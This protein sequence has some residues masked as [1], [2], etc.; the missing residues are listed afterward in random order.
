MLLSAILLL[1]LAAGIG[2]LL[3]REDL[4]EP[5]QGRA[6]GPA[7][8]SSGGAPTGAEPA[9]TAP[10][11]WLLPAGVRDPELVGFA[12]WTNDY[13]TANPVERA[14]ILPAG[15]ELATARRAFLLA[16]IPR[17]PAS[18]LAAAV[19][20]EVRTELPAAIVA[21]LEVPV[22][23]AGEYLVAI[24]CGDRPDHDPASH[25]GE[26][27]PDGITRNLILA[28]ELWHAFPYGRRLDT[29]TKTVIS[30]HGIGLDGLLAMDANPLRILSAAE[31]RERSLSGEGIP[32][33]IAGRLRML[34]DDSALV[35][36]VSALQA[37]E[38]RL[39]PHPG[40]ALRAALRGDPLP[41]AAALEGPALTPVDETETAE[42]A[43]TEGPKTFLYIRARFAD[44]EADF[45]PIVLAT[46]EAHQE[47]VNQFI[48]NASYGKLPS[49]TTTFTDVVTL[50]K[51]GS[52]YSGG[53]A[54]ALT[55]LLTDA[56]DAAKA[57]NPA[58]DSASFDFDVVVTSNRGNFPY[59][60]V[61]FVGGKGMHL[62]SDFT[63]LRT[64]GH[65][66]GHNLGLWHANYWRTDALSPI[67]RDSAPGGYVPDGVNA[68][69]VEYGHRF[70]LMSAQS[71]ADFDNPG[72]P[73]F[74]VS[75]KFRL[76]WISASDG[77]AS[78]TSTPASGS[79]FRISRQDHPAAPDTRAV[80]IDVPSTDYTTSTNSSKRRYWLSYRRAFTSGTMGTYSPYGVQVDWQ[81]NSYGSDGAIQLDMTPYTADSTTYY[82]G[83]V[84]PN[85]WWTIDNT[86]KEDAMLPIGLTYSDPAGIHITPLATGGIDGNAWIDVEVRLGSFPE[87]QPPTLT[88]SASQ[89]NPAVGQSVTFTAAAAD[90]DD[91][92]LSYWWDFGDRS[93]VPAALD[94]PVATKS[95][96]SPG[97]RTVRLIVSDRRGGQAVAQ[98][99]VTVGQPANTREIRGR[100]LHG[101]YPVVG[102]RVYS[103]STYQA[104][105]DSEGR[106]LLVGLPSNTFTLA[107]Q[108]DDLTF[109]A[110]FTN[111]VSTST[112]NAYG[113]DF[114]A[115]EP[116]ATASPSYALAGTVSAGGAGL[117]GIPVEAG[118]LRTVTGPDGSYS[119][120]QLAP[121]TY[122]VRP[123]KAG[124]TY[125]PTSRAVTITS[126]NIS[127]QNFTEDR[128]TVTGRV[129]GVPSNP[130]NA[131]NPPAVFLLDGTT[132][133]T[134][135]VNNVGWDYTLAV[136]S[137]SWSIHATRSSHAVVPSFTNPVAVAGNLSGMDFSGE[138]SSS[139]RSLSGRIL[140]GDNGLAGVTVTASGGFAGST[141]TDAEG[142]YRFANLGS[143][144]VT[145]EASLAGFTFATAPDSSNPVSPTATV[146]FLATSTG[147]ATAL[148]VLDGPLASAATLPAPGSVDL[149]VSATGNGPFLYHWAATSGNGPVTFSANSS[150]GAD[151]TTATFSTPGSYTCTVFVTDAN[152]FTVSAA[153]V[154]EVQAAGGVLVLSPYEVVINAGETI[155]FAATR[156]D[157]AGT[158]GP[159]AP[160]FAVSGGGPIDPATGS[161][162]GANEGTHSV[163][164]TLGGLTAQATVTVIGSLAE[165]VITQDPLDQAGEEFGSASF[166]VTATGHE[167]LSFQWFHDGNPLTDDERRSGTTTSSLLIS[168][169]EP[170]DAGL[171]R[172]VVS[173]IAGSALSAAATL[174]V[175]P[176]PSFQNW[177]EDEYPQ[178]TGPDAEPLADPDGDGIPNLLEYALGGSPDD[179]DDAPWPTSSV[180]DPSEPGE[181]R[182]LQMTFRRARPELTYIIE[183]SDDLAN[184]TTIA[185]NPGEVGTDVEVTDPEPFTP[186]RPR[187]LRLRVN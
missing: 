109:T 58:W 130:P 105:T 81:R 155:T 151:A 13:I 182:H 125:A 152:G 187:F 84:T 184:W 156:F 158:P 98:V 11:P 20:Y 80:H 52:E 176:A 170:A 74:A 140:H 5:P 65:E 101:G 128:F 165:P 166:T 134:S 87:N 120:T 99:P 44:E 177:I 186:T 15:I 136:P 150:A 37:D 142:R 113:R 3:Q 22:S 2:G 70:S 78:I 61:A 138:S 104:W 17:D 129:T 107:A 9:P 154:V 173:N 29:T 45:V 51:N 169:L 171:Y 89:L 43:W 7:L 122:T 127:A 72:R 146:N 64:A 185:T 157:E 148:P 67:G 71:G 179:P 91:D 8:A 162:T 110:Q 100:V 46:V 36:W 147:S 94:Q 18:A 54:Q 137:G 50:P 174:T 119:F 83:N 42:S 47:A 90:P 19:P 12:A 63:S 163:T 66:F 32:V 86:D 161:F 62:R 108:H 85:G 6:T 180:S 131:S 95:W 133:S 79:V 121:G 59:A 144:G 39:G 167:P 40:P 73:H 23:G 159:A 175:T 112:G 160:S 60:G 68:E 97:M 28:A 69:W 141:L 24:A 132:A 75:E 1:L 178:L 111:P 114:Y 145:L 115:N 123:L 172:C 57:A 77:L 34:P 153:T 116:L 126:A 139:D 118:G 82:D 21:Q 38:R 96:S 117:A 102:A 149:T 53:T 181:P 35:A 56:R 135:R 164:A 48:H 183:A 26:P 49:L 88:L 93:V 103:G 27:C 10:A 4:P 14:R 55:A 16:L 106:Y 76:D 92:T 168:G 143:S 25:A 41:P 30:A 33:E 124:R 31:A